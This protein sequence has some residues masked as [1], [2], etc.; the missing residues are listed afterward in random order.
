MVVG[1]L[2]FVGGG[3]EEPVG[4]QADAGDLREPMRQ[5][6]E[7]GVPVGGG[8]Q[9]VEQRRPFGDGGGEVVDDAPVEAG[10]PAGLDGRVLPFA[11][12][13]GVGGGRPVRGPPHGEV[14]DG[15]GV[16]AEAARRRPR[17]ELGGRQRLVAHLVGEFDDECVTPLQVVAPVVVAG[18]A[19]RQTGQPGQGSGLGVASGG[20]FEAPVEDGGRVGGAA[21]LAGLHGLGERPDGVGSG[22]GDQEQ[23][24]AE[25][26]P[27]RSIG[28]SGDELV[29]GLFEAAG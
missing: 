23:V 26:G 14:G 20:G 27:R 2:A 13:S 16:R 7:V 11:G 9:L 29:G 1:E 28:E 8:R 21:Q 12:G 5:H 25:R 19:G 17:R 6:G 3:V 22:R 10:L 18:E 24:G 4:V 15:G